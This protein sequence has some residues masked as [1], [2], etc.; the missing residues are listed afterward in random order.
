MSGNLSR[1]F[2]KGVGHF[3]RG[4]Q[5]EGG[6][7]DQ[8]LLA[9][10]QQSDCPFVWYKNICSASFSFVT[11]HACDRQT[12][13][14]TDRITTPKTALAYA[15]AV[16]TSTYSDIK[17]DKAAGDDNMDFSW[18]DQSASPIWLHNGWT[19]IIET[20][21]CSSLPG[22][23]APAELPGERGKKSRKVEYHQHKGGD[24]G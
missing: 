5:R 7:A 24:S 14:Q 10:E 11:I 19:I 16:K 22:A 18:T 4:F 23:A 2:S 12:D 17:V 20:L 8:P 9:S 15:R 13:R 3:E 1:R 21:F 6:V